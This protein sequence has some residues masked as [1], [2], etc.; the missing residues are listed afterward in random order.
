MVRKQMEVK[1][2]PISRGYVE[3]EHLPIDLS[4]IKRAQKAGVGE[5]LL[6]L[7]EKVLEEVEQLGITENNYDDVAKIIRVLL[8]VFSPIYKRFHAPYIEIGFFI[9]PDTG[10]N[11][12]YL[13][14]YGIFLQADIQIEEIDVHNMDPA[15]IWRYLYPPS[16]IVENLVSTMIAVAEKHQSI[17]DEWIISFQQIRDLCLEA[18]IFKS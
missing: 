12:V 11:T 2:G 5:L 3:A 10:A 6:K 9:S 16:K 13:S 18:E 14:E 1:D 17:R 4:T 8:D 15:R 7:S